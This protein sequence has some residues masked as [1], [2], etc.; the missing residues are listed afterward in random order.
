[1]DRIV[2]AVI[3]SSII[4]PDLTTSYSPEFVRR[5]QVSCKVRREEMKHDHSRPQCPHDELRSQVSTPSRRNSGHPNLC[6]KQALD[7]HLLKREKKPSEV[8]HFFPPTAVCTQD[9]QRPFPSRRCR[10]ISRASS[11]APRLSQTPGLAS[12]RC[13][14]Q[15][16]VRNHVARGQ[17]GVRI[18][19]GCRDG[20]L[21]SGRRRCVIRV[22]GSERAEDERRSNAERLGMDTGGRSRWQPLSSMVRITLRISERCSL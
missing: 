13:M 8:S 19:F 22:S 21:R 15:G 2:H 18:L 16:A 14:L 6:L 9:W 17:R 12:D 11:H 3:S 1:M 20:R 5:M 7:H 4:T 10:S